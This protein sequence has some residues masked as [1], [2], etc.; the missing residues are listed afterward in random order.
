[1][2]IDF[3]DVFDTPSGGYP[4]TLPPPLG[5]GAVPL[6]ILTEYSAVIWVGNNYD[7]DLTLWNSSPVFLYVKFGGNL[8]LMTREAKSFISEEFRQYL[9]IT[10]ADAA[11]ST[12]IQNCISV[13]T[14]L[15]SISVNDST[16]TYVDV[17][18]TTLA[19][20]ESKLLYKETQT[21]SGE[22]GLGVWKRPSAGGEFRQTGGQV[23]LLAFRP[24]RVSTQ[25]LKTNV[26]YILHT[27]FGVQ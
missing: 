11:S 19:T 23:V 7:G 1:M 10:W 4:A 13:Y 20:T 9:G 25:N 14:G 5:H 15:T 22:R 3:W 24:Y 17:F 18:L 6:N 16:N 26:E 2:T 12:F 8:L 21:F 27:F